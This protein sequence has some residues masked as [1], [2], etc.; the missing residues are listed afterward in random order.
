M[1]ARLSSWKAADIQ[2]VGKDQLMDEAGKPVEVQEDGGLT[3]VRR[4]IQ[5]V[6]CMS[7]SVCFSHTY[8]TVLYV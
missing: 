4:M 6:A 8:C 5:L 7:T 3:P 2:I 1:F